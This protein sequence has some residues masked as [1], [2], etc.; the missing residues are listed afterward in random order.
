MLR[1]NSQIGG[2][3]VVLQT[4]RNVIVQP[5]NPV[6]SPS[7]SP[8]VVVR[9]S[10]VVFSQYVT[11]SPMSCVVICKIGG[12]FTPG[13]QL[14]TTGPEMQTTGP[15]MWQIPVVAFCKFAVVTAKS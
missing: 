5:H 14:T 1:C 15:L 4:N 3:T 7:H 2:V 9:A 12:N 13:Q 6:A 10:F 8:G 11:L